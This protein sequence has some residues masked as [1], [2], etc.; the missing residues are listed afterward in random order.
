MEETRVGHRS[1]SL[2]RYLSVRGREK[3]SEAGG[4]GGGKGGSLTQR[5]PFLLR[6]AGR[7]LCSEFDSGR[8]ADTWTSASMCRQSWCAL[9]L[10]RKCL[11]LC[12]WTTWLYVL[13]YVAGKAFFLFVCFFKPVSNFKPKGILE[14]QKSAIKEREMRDTFHPVLSLF[15]LPMVDVSWASAPTWTSGILPAHRASG[16]I[17]GREHKAGSQA[18]WGRLVSMQIIQ[19]FPP[20]WPYP[21][22]CPLCT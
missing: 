4:N 12:S 7:R 18:C 5:I 21:L 11:G 13:R 2:K 22:G 16:V 1:K 9:E 8:F 3:A 10:E 15:Q 17:I 6:T 20:T 19:A 14:E